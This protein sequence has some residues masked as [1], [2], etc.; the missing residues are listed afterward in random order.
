MSTAKKE[1]SYVISVSLGT[2]C[3]RHI[4][5][6]SKARL[7]EL[8][9][10]ILDAFEFIDDHAHAFFMNNRA[11][12]EEEAYYSDIIE[13]EDR[14]TTDYTLEKLHLYPDMKFKYVFDFGEEWLFQCKVL[15]ILDEITDTPDVIRS[16]GESPGQYEW[17]DEDFDDE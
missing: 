2:G 9:E 15:K 8:H 4:Q 1:V 14:Y 5:I 17:A 16:K 3:Y 12:S 10:A 7:V 6:S 11:W 13:G